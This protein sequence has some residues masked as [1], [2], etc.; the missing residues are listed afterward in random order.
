MFDYSSIFNGLTNNY[1]SNPICI[2]EEMD[3]E[4]FEEMKENT[5]VTEEDIEEMDDEYGSEEDLYAIY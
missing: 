4:E 5:Y 3:E 2:S 1:S